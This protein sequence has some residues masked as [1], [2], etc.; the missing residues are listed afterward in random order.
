[1]ILSDEFLEKVYEK[2]M[3]S[4]YDRADGKEIILKLLRD[5]SARKEHARQVSSRDDFV[6]PKPPAAWESK[7]NRPT[8]P[9]YD[10]MK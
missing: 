5:I 9:P 3:W 1:M 7:V 10:S 8:P 6:Q 2:V 4:G